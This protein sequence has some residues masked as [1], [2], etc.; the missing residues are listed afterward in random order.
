M[1]KSLRYV[2][3]YFIGFFIFVLGLPLLIILTAKGFD[4]FLYIKLINSQNVRAIIAVP[5][6]LFGIIFVI[7][8]N[9]ALI[10]IGKGGPLEGAGVAVSPPTEKLVISGPYKYTRNPMVFGTLSV[11]VS[12]AVFLDS[13]LT[14]IVLIILMSIMANYLKFSEEKRLL[15]DFGDEFIE[16]KKKV[17]LLIPNFLIKKENQ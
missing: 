7:W 17:P 16:Y 4:T 12:L 3:G 8:S 10:K 11:Y 13:V 6:F 1:K 15:K 14:L 5:F 9:I 2:L